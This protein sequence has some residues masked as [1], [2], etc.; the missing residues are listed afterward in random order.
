L[1]R[2]ASFALVA[3]AALGGCEQGNDGDFDFD[4]ETGASAT[5]TTATTTAGTGTTGTETGSSGDDDPATTEA[6]STTETGNDDTSGTDESTGGLPTEPCTTIDVLVVIDNS[7][8]MAEEQARL[9]VALGPFIALLDEQLPGVLGS[10]HVAVIT[11]DAPEFVITTPA[12]ECSPYASAASWMLYGPTLSTE[13]ACASAVGT[14]GDPDE[15]PMQMAIEALS[16][17]LINIDGFNEGFLR[18][19]GPL[20]VLIVTDEEDDFEATPVWG[21]QVD[22][23]DDMI[24][25]VSEWVDALAATQ[26]GHVQNVIPL[27]LVGPVEEPNACPDVWNGMDGAETATRIVEFAESFPHHVIGDI[28]D[29]EYTTFLNGSVP[30]IAAACNA[31]VPE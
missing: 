15:R 16:P 6:P 30:T 10:I 1:R 2:L 4:A 23:N 13:L 20:V 22:L 9:N 7:D 24:Y 11:T 19:Q 12:G 31:W 14:M 21:S 8:A 5:L 28:C 17:E 18:E 29:V 3:V 26:D 25:S 27:V